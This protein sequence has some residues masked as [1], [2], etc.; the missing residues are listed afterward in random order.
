MEPVW[1]YIY[2]EI[3]RAEY[4][5]RGS[6]MIGRGG[7]A[8]RDARKTSVLR[9]KVKHDLLARVPFLAGANEELISDLAASLVQE[10]YAAGETVFIEGTEGNKFYLVASGL[11][12][13]NKRG[14]NLADLGPGS[15]IGEGSL[16]TDHPRSAT[17]TACHESTLFF[18][19]RAS[20]S[21]LT[22]AYPDVRAQLR[23]LHDNR[24]VG[25]NIS[26]LQRQLAS[27]LPFLRDTSDL[28]LVAD[29]ANQ[30]KPAFCRAGEILIKEGEMGDLFYII[31]YGS[32]RISRQGETLALLGTGGCLGEGALLSSAVRSATATAVEDTGLLTLDR[33][34]FQLI[35]DS[36]PQMQ[37]TLSEL[38]QTRSATP[39]G[40][41]V[42]PMTAIS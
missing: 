25:I 4:A 39:F 34:C 1:R 40:D 41:S 11:V 14:E 36:Y 12:R 27:H 30:L 17:V 16:L 37:T 3:F 32:L 2:Y 31:E 35:L 5:R 19:T 8:G 42:A 13:V 24:R 20:F 38:H 22:E 21:Y 23:R 33:Q 29:L 28:G 10:R 7:S 9:E 18:L 15:C 6:E 26:M